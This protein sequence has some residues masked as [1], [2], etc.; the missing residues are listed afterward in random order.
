MIELTLPENS[1]KYLVLT[2]KLEN[3]SVPFKVLINE[4]IELPVIKEGL[5]EYSGHEEIFKFL[6]EEEIFVKQ[7][8]ECRCGNHD[9]D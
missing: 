1:G 9:K 6:E 8:Y 5:K 2:D 3:L 4:N 7:W